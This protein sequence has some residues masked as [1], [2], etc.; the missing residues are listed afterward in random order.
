MGASP[1]TTVTVSFAVRASE[2]AEAAKAVAA[3][4]P[5][6]PSESTDTIVESWTMLSKRS[7]E[8]VGQQWSLPFDAYQIEEGY[9]PSR[10][11]QQ[12]DRVVPRDILDFPGEVLRVFTY[13]D[14]RPSVEVVWDEITDS[15]EREKH[16][17]ELALVS[18]LMLRTEGGT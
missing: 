1:Y 8:A 18:D 9:Q 17:D 3:L 13:P 14:G 5:D 7:A 11:F 2:E 10:P 16:P 12:G 4:L 6:Y 15:T